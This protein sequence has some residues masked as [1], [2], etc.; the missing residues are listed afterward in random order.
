MLSIALLA[1]PPLALA[2]LMACGGDDATGGGG[3]SSSSTTSS[4]A[5]EGGGGGGEA[6][7]GGTGGGEGGAGGGEGGAGGGEVD[8]EPAD[9]LLISEVAAAPGAAEFI[10]IWNPT[11][12]EIDLTDYYLSDNSVYYAITAGEVWMPTASAGTDFLVQFPP[13]TMIPA[14]GRLVLASDEGFELEYQ[15]C[16]DFALDESP[17]PCEGGDVPPMI[18][19]TNGA[20]GAQAGA[21]LTDSGEMVILFEWDGT[22]G[23][24]LKDVDYVIWGQELGNS[25]MAYKTGKKGYADDTARGSQRPTAAAGS[26][27][28]I[29]RCSDREFGELLTEGN[30]ISGHDETS[31]WLDI[32]FTVASTPTPG[33]ENDCP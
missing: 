10:E 15:R 23:S 8:G 31:E 14:G 7:A 20:L 28:S 6:G 2:H 32:S 30:G 12:T 18:A 17:I 1:V 21:L 27:S 5:G 13:G 29:A 3:A 9:H 4:S 25:A 26:G 19:P 22:E 24:P 33:E 16:A 11:E